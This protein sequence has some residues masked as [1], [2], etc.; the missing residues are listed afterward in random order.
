[1][2]I[3]LLVQH[4]VPALVEACKDC[5]GQGWTAEVTGNIY[6]GICEQ[7]QEW[8]GKCSGNGFFIM[9]DT[10]EKMDSGRK[11]ICPEQ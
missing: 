11:S 5:N 3:T 8:C 10:H 7:H 4:T 6:N 9:K 2:N 1:M